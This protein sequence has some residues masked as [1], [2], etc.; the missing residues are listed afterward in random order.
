MTTKQWYDALYDELVDGGFKLDSHESDLYVKDSP[1][2]REIIDKHKLPYKPFIDDIDH[3]R[4]L[5]VPF[6]YAPFW[7]EKAKAG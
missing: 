5:E 2:A 7:R 6:A 4:W 3:E 1:L